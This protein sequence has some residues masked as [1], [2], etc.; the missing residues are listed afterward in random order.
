MK[1]IKKTVG[2]INKNRHLYAIILTD[3]QEV[4]ADFFPDCNSWNQYKNQ[5]IEVI[6]HWKPYP[7][8][9]TNIRMVDIK[10]WL[11]ESDY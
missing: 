8:Y 6:G 4:W 11:K 10:H 9:D 1:G 3:G 7:F 2:E 5:A